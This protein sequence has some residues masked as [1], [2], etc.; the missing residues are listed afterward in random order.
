MPLFSCWH[1]LISLSLISPGEREGSSSQSPSLQT[2]GAFLDGN[3][4]P[5]LMVAFQN[6]DFCIGYIKPYN[7]AVL[8]LKIFNEWNGKLENDHA[9]FFLTHA[10]LFMFSLPGFWKLSIAISR[11][12]S[13]HT[14]KS[15]NTFTLNIFT[16]KIIHV[17]GGGESRG[18]D[19][20][21][22]SSYYFRK[23]HPHHRNSSSSSSFPPPSFQIWSVFK[24]EIHSYSISPE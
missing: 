14:F 11:L 19:L 18:G 21:Y 4:F 23:P 20:S 6:F 17:L 16:G 2:K 5:I 13:F 9:G 3:F 10:I 22:S 15:R 7:C 12:H 1:C 24:Y 8:K